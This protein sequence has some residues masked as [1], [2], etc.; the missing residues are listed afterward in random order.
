MILRLNA[1]LT[2]PD[3]KVTA[4][5]PTG[6]TI[7]TQYEDTYPFQAY[8]ILEGLHGL[9]TTDWKAKL[10]KL[11]N[12][13]PD[14]GLPTPWYA[15][16]VMAIMGREERR[17]LEKTE[18]PSIFRLR[19]PDQLTLSDESTFPDYP[20]Q[21]SQIYKGKLVLDIIGSEGSTDTY[22]LSSE[23]T[24]TYVADPDAPIS[25]YLSSTAVNPRIKDPGL[26]NNSLPITKLGPTVTGTFT[27]QNPLVAG[28][29]EPPPSAEF[30]LEHLVLRFTMEFEI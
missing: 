18:F 21:Q 29:P 10:L 30:H 17:I 8:T 5:H 28:V 7:G 2:F 4:S 22:S 26:I 14:F 6:P 12:D 27:S 1:W 25:G 24:L 23:V 20:A 11:D 9:E 16:P 13:S 15:L 19:I 3:G